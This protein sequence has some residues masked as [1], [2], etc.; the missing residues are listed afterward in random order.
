MCAICVQSIYDTQQR[1]ISGLSTVTAAKI[2]YALPKLHIVLENDAEL[3]LTQLEFSRMMSYMYVCIYAWKQESWVHIEREGLL[4]LIFAFDVGA[5]NL[6]F[7]LS[8]SN[9]IQAMILE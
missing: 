9:T 7:A 3:L 1:T 2:D 4:I 8:S 5:N 6:S